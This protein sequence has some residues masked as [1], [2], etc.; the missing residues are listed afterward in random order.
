[1]RITARRDP[2]VDPDSKDMGVPE[3][4]TSPAA[5]PEPA[6]VGKHGTA[7]ISLEGPALAAQLG[8]LSLRL[9]RLEEALEKRVK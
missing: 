4:G 1:V 3:S 2:R 6:K 5:S 7:V 9:T 8:A